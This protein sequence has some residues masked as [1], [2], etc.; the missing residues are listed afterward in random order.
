MSRLSKYQMTVLLLAGPTATRTPL[1]N[2]LY[3][4]SAEQWRMAFVGI[5]CKFSLRVKLTMRPAVFCSDESIQLGIH[6]QFAFSWSISYEGLV[7][8][9]GSNEEA[10]TLLFDL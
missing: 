10:T 3:R 1:I 6:T 8:F 4:V 5:D 2:N 9:P 7:V